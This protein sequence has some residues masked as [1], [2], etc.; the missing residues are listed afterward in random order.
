MKLYK[1]LFAL[2]FAAFCAGCGDD[3]SSSASSEEESSSSRIASYKSSSS[4]SNRAD[5]AYN[6]TLE[7]GDTVALD[8]EIPKSKKDI[9]EES[10]YIYITDTTKYIRLFLGEF[11][12]GTRINVHIVSSGMSKDTIRIQNE[13]G[14]ELNTL[15]PVWNE[16]KKDSVFGNYMI[17]GHDG[18]MQ[19]MCCSCSKEG[20]T[21]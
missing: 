4:L 1:I 17:P 16:S 20:N 13:I 12:K 19:E 10:G 14:D 6:D 3:D 11:V 18:K 5:I 8:F 2:S 9:D 15:K 21:G 7:L